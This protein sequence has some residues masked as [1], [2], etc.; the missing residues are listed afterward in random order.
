M[1]RILWRL[2]CML[3]CQWKGHTDIVIRH[4]DLYP[5]PTYVACL[6]CYRKRP[7][8]HEELKS[9][10]EPHIP[11]LTNPKYAI[12]T[13]DRTGPGGESGSDD[14]TVRDVRSIQKL[15][16]PEDVGFR[17]EPFGSVDFGGSPG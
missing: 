5:I 14:A 10:L 8:T 13:K 16:L 2:W 9:L 4:P 12:P 11:H 6:Q 7:F 17:E 1:Y 3:Q 15:S